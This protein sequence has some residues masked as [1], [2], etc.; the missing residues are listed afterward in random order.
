[1]SLETFLIDLLIIIPLVYAVIYKVTEK[2]P[3]TK[4]HNVWGSNKERLF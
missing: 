1:M 4:I 3:R 2:K